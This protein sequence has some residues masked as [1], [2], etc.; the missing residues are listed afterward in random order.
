MQ[1]KHLVY[2]LLMMS[3]GLDAQV[4]IKGE[5]F[6]EATGEPIIGAN[7][8]IEGTTEGVVTEWDGSFELNTSQKFPFTITVSYLGYVTQSIEVSDAKQ[9]IKFNLADQSITVAEVEVVGQRISDKQK[10]APLTVESLDAISIKQTASTDFYSGLGSLKGVDLTT[11]SIGFTIIN[12]R[13]FNSTSPVRSLQIIDGVDN[14]SPGLNFSLGNFLGAPELDIQKVDLVVGA[15]SAYY[16]P[17]AF[18]GAIS[19]ETKNPF[20]S[21]GLS[22]SVKAGERSLLEGSLRYANVVKNSQGLDVLGYKVNFFGMRANDWQADND[23]PV[24]DSKSAAS[25]PGGYDKVNTYGDEYSRTLD[26]NNNALF[27]QYA[28]LGIFHRTGYREKD[29]V[30]YESKNLKGN[31]GLYYRLKPSMAEE[32][33]ELIYGFNIGNGTTV[34]QGDNRFSLRNITFFQN[35]LEIRKRDKYF[36]RF[37]QTQEDAGDSYD[38]YFTSLLLAGQ[39]KDNVNWGS[40]YV[41]YWQDEVRP[42]MDELGYPKLQIMI[43]PNTGGITTSFDTIAANKWL[44]DNAAFIKASHDAA[45]NHA[46][47]LER[48][49]EYKKYLVPGSEE[50]KTA[51]NKIVTTKS[52]KRTDE[53]AGTQFFDRSALYHMQG[54][55]KFTPTFMESIVIGGSARHYRPNS[56]GTI[57][58]DTSNVKITNTEFGVYLGGEK[59]LVGSKLKLNATI[60]AD[61]NQNFN[62]LFSPAFSAVYNPSENNFLR[63][64]FS[65][66]LRNPTLTDQFLFL[67]VG[68]AILSGNLN[69]AQD[70][71]TVESFSDFTENLDRSQLKYFNI[72]GVRPEKVKTME[73]GYRTTLFNNTYID[74]SYYY[75][76]YND[77][78]G[79]VIGIKSDFDPLTS[80]PQNIQA[81][82]YAANS[83]NQVTTQ[84]FSVGLNHYFMEHYMLAGNY[85]WNK[86]NKLDVDDPIIPA[87]NTPEHKYNISLSGRDVHG[88]GLNKFGFNVNYKWVSSF[89]FEGSPQFTGRIPSYALVDAQINFALS[90]LNAVIKIGASNVLNNKIYQTYGGPRIGRMAYISYLYD[91]KIK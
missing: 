13:G 68:P 7:V 76:R 53:E 11:A 42:Q 37:Y 21:K 57:F 78:L 52:N 36:L 74:G 88:L 35:K 48:G 12:T 60:R 28:G 86:L 62:A 22:A 55:Y 39:S 63:L 20:Y 81:Y 73:I 71:I 89:I 61:K 23:E 75:S 67:N 24:F 26:Y 84:G 4:K 64:S 8:I 79:Y 56:Q 66:A 19:M 27:S 6:E 30:N 90:K 32:S 77:F 1:L 15:S 33:P 17:N 82:R 49:A 58:Y 83:T 2:L 85:S 69:G 87:F 59:K 91:F 9:K 18:N 29:V 46:D 72:A 54:E 80:F 70:L 47:T 5:V 16:A 65:S 25:N 43:D 41:K 38:P 10:S 3:F 34:Y 50:F 51:F 44:S 31:V 45:R 40:D 14:Q